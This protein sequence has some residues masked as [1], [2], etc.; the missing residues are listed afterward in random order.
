MAMIEETLTSKFVSLANEI[1]KE[2]GVMVTG[3]SLDWSQSYGCSPFAT[4]ARIEYESYH[5]M[6]DDKK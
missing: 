5:F 3:I 6:G 4:K 1:A 2:T